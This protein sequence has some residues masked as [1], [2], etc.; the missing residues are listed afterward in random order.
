MAMDTEPYSRSRLA[1]V[2]VRDMD[3]WLLL[4]AGFVRVKKLSLILSFSTIIYAY[5]WETHVWLSSQPCV[6]DRGGK[7]KAL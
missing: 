1:R 2:S 6:K 3:L 4:V 7:C 5:Y